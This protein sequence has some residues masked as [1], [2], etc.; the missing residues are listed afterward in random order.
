MFTR[1]F[2]SK[3]LLTL[4]LLIGIAGCGNTGDLYLPENASMTQSNNANNIES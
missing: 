1:F 3:A 4:M 2:L